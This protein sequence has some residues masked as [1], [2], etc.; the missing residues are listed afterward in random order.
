MCRKYPEYL[1]LENAP[2][3]DSNPKLESLN[4]SRASTFYAI[5]SSTQLWLFIK[6]EAPI[7]N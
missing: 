4:A 3:S 7:K 5:L 2:K 1:L 6:Q